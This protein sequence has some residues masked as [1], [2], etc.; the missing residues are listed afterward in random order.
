MR[1]G[2]IV[3][4]VVA[5]LLMNS[6]ASGRLD[7]G[8]RQLGRLPASPALVETQL[9]PATPTR[10]STAKIVV[11]VAPGT[12]PSSDGLQVILDL[13][14][15]GGL[16]ATSL[17]DAG[18]GACDEIGG[19][20]AFTGCF[21][22]PPAMPPATVTLPGVIRDA[23]GRT[24]PF[25][26]TISAGGGGDADGDGLGDGCE[27]TFGL[28]ASSS[29]G[30]NGADGDPDGDGVL[31]AQECAGATHPRGLF[32]RYL[33]EGVS[34]AFFRT[35][36]AL[37]NPS[38][39]VVN[40]LVR[41]QPEGAPERAMM[42]AVPGQ[43]RR[44]LLPEDVMTI[45]DAPFA[46]VVESDSELVV[47]RLVSWGAATYGSHAETAVKAPST[48][49]YLAEGATGWRFSLFYLLQNPTANEAQVQVSYLRGA[50]DPVLTRTYIVGPRQRRTIPVDDEQFP[51][52]S[53]TTPLAATD[54]S[55]VITSLNGVP[56][57]VERAMYMSPD[58]QPFGAGHAASGVTAPATTWSFAEGATG[59]F[60]DEFILLANPGHATAN[61]SITF[62]PEGQASVTR[63]LDLAP[64]SR[65]TIWVDQEPGLS[66][67]ALS[68]QIAATEPIV[69]ERAMWW[70]G[71]GES[72]REAH[73]SA[74]STSTGPRWA[75]ADLEIGGPYNADSY[76]LIANG[77][78]LTV[79]FDDGTPPVACGSAAAGRVTFRVNECPGVAG[80]RFVSAI[81]EG[82]AQTTV[83]RAVYY[84]TVSMFAA[85]G[86]AL[87][88]QL[89]SGNTSTTTIPASGG[90]A[91]LPQTAVVAFPA[92]SLPAGS[93]VALSATS[94]PQTDEDFTLTTSV[95]STVGRLAYEVRIETGTTRPSL[96]TIVTLPM[97]PAF[98]Q[99][100]PANGEVQA[101][102]QIFQD[103]GDELID[104]FELIPSTINGNTITFVLGPE[105][106]TT[107]RRLDD[108]YEAIVTLGVTPTKA[109]AVALL[110]LPS[111]RSIVAPS[112]LVAASA[113]QCE[114]ASLGP[115]LATVE[116]RWPFDPKRPHYGSDLRAADGTPVLAMA[117]GVVKEIRHQAK[118]LPQPNPRSG[119]M[120]QGWGHMIVIE[121]ADKSKTLYAHLQPPGTIPLK[122]NDPVK[123]GQVIAL[124]DNSGGSE[125]PHL[126]IEYAP[127]G[128]IY[129]KPSKVDAFACIGANV[130]GSIT[131]SD[132][133]NLADDAF[134]V[135]INGLTVCQ[136]SIGA[137]NTCAVGNLR[138]GNAI[139]TITAIVAPDDVGTFEIRLSNGLTF[140]GGGTTQSGIVP[141]L[142]SESFNI[143]IPAST[144]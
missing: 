57:V 17:S 73:V 116:E 86:A 142:G 126:H 54:V 42:I 48:T 130:E 35:R 129:D 139:L 80:K 58:G 52:G 43:T 79:Y 77:G 123:K 28:D 50:A 4:V 56:I 44:T 20:R 33:A 113:G 144:P 38:S 81:V 72:W 13:S 21:L 141:A 78:A 90:S 119:K 19:D 125:A 99:Q 49:W 62:S 100:L 107:A 131:V 111:M 64:H 26:F 5:L 133:G 61:V 27:T 74:G 87:A 14:A 104:A 15:L 51:E 103:G 132:N 127:N 47:D 34:N 29:A 91:T 37:F 24:S 118:P 8:A 95:F 135:A 18:G 55:A 98:L 6:S 85:G 68:T 114:G 7:A 110:S 67:G 12:D 84:S 112:G 94:Q 66:D 32:S 3:V 59:S 101:F 69:A 105:A 137:T 31:N 115:P 9:T 82:T 63:S 93:Q 41:I 70:P 36:I 106:F 71:S 16:A 75:V 88:T 136:T 30:P 60:F 11:R 45:T 2:T 143:V 122:V 140:Q 1:N 89:P 65:H 102:A 53:G 92:G 138:P 109:P 46:T 23:Q 108:I 10:G 120:V 128:Q 25:S 134:R 76:V 22:I 83:E 97:P 96:D 39:S 117:D 124:S 121:H 40:A